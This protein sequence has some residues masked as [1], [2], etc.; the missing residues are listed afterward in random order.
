MAASARAQ[1]LVARA[2]QL[3]A[4]PDGKQQNSPAPAARPPARPAASAVDSKHGGAPAPL[5]TPTLDALARELAI[6]EKA[7][8]MIAAARAA[9]QQ[10]KPSAAGAGASTAES[11]YGPRHPPPRPLFRV[12]PNASEKERESMLLEFCSSN[13]L[14]N[15]TGPNLETYAAA[16]ILA[17]SVGDKPLAFATLKGP[18]RAAIG[19]LVPLQAHRPTE[20]QIV[21][22]A[23]Y[24]AAHTAPN[25]NAAKAPLPPEW[26]V[27][28][29]RAGT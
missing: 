29:V 12:P 22:K 13:N 17:R 6:E 10:P 25:R 5:A 14:T 11:F 8:A 23:L 4:A 2:R 7:R 27:K 9:A 26:L 1:L 19:A 18:V 21:R 20:T 28:V 24:A 16:F 3:M 15:P